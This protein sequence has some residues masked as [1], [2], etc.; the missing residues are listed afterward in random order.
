MTVFSGRLLHFVCNKTTINLIVLLL[1]LFSFVKFCEWQSL[2]DT[3]F[4]IIH[5]TE[6]IFDTTEKSVNGNYYT[7]LKYEPPEPI[8]LV[9]TWVNGTDERLLEQMSQYTNDHEMHSNR[10]SDNN[11]LMYSLRSIEKFAP[12]V[13]HI[14]IVTNG[15]IPSWLNLENP[16]ISVVPHSDIVQPEMADVALP[17]FSSMAIEMMLHRIP[18]LSERFIYMNDDIFL[19]HPLYLEDMRSEQ[20]GIYVLPTMELRFCADTCKWSSIGNGVCNDGCN[21]AACNFDGG[22]CK[23]FPLEKMFANGTDI[24]DLAGVRPDPL[25]AKF[26]L[27]EASL[28]D[29][30]L[31]SLI[32]SHEILSRRYG[33]KKRKMIAHVGFLIDRNVMYDIEKIFPDDVRS[34]ESHRFRHGRDSLQYALV[35]HEVLLNEKR[36]RTNDEIFDEYDTDKDG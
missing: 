15:Q 23:P 13:R 3:T 6:N 33:F 32:H 30:Y 12:W 5:K 24:E 2:Y 17:T 8:D 20:K 9:Y 28:Q 26:L 36:E 10:F 35:Y 21:L 22:D 31:T 1:I 14:Y 19:G 18:N 29:H 4:R 27:D 7:K 25:P 11:E 34:T 16:R